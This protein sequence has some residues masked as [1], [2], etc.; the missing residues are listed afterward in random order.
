MKYSQR[1]RNLLRPTSWR[2]RLCYC[3]AALNAWDQKKNEKV[4]KKIASY[5]KVIQDPKET[6]SDFLQRLTSAIN[7]LSEAK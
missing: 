7:R 6:F 3:A 1:Y 4:E 5:T 2:R